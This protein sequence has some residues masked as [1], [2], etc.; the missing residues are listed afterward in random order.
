[1]R[2]TDRIWTEDYEFPDLDAPSKDIDFWDKGLHIQPDPPSFNEA[3]K[4]IV[5]GPEDLL[6]LTPLYAV[7]WTLDLIG[8]VTEM[9]LASVRAYNAVT[10]GSPKVDMA[11]AYANGVASWKGAFE[12]S[13]HIVANLL[14]LSENHSGSPRSEAF[15]K[16]YQDDFFSLGYEQKFN[17]MLMDLGGSQRSASES[18]HLGDIGP[19]KDTDAFGRGGYVG[20]G[21]D[22]SSGGGESNDSDSD[23]DTV[24]V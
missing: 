4:S 16:M 2:H 1:M 21:P 20:D 12:I 7:M 11:L 17:D 19:G 23:T 13:R 24:T 9:T 15:E 10:T 5:D 6:K 22:S 8:I 14:D 3:T 18:S